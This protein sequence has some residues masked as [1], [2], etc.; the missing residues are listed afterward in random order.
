MPSPP[1][2]ALDLLLRVALDER[3]DDLPELVWRCSRAKLHS[4]GH[5]RFERVPDAPGTD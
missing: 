4:S 5:T 1:L 2:W 3:R